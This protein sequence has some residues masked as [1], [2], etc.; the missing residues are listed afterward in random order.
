MVRLTSKPIDLEALHQELVKDAKSCGGVVVFEG[1]VRN[2]SHGKPV[3][4]LSYECY[5]PMAL[6]EMEKISQEAIKKWRVERI[7]ADAPSWRKSP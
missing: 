5:E 3:T 2:H 1:R 7:T 6:K 4:A